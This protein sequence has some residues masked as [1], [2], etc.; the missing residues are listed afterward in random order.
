M[1]S[2]MGSSISMCVKIDFLYRLFELFLPPI[3]IFKKSNTITLTKKS[4]KQ[5]VWV[6]WLLEKSK[7]THR[8]FQVMLHN[9]F[10]NAFPHQ[11]YLLGFEVDWILTGKCFGVLLGSY[12]PRSAPSRGRRQNK[13]C[14]TNDQTPETEIKQNTTFTYWGSETN[15]LL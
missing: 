6:K 1:L 4:Q 15:T 10:Y 3:P 7:A 12:L 11:I 2:L 8:R 9:H 13:I 5:D 14:N